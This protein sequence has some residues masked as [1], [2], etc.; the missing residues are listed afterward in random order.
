LAPGVIG[1]TGARIDGVP[2]AIARTT[3]EAPDLYR[4]L[5][6]MRHAGVGA[7]AMEVSSHALAQRR[8]DGMRFDAAVFTNLSH[9]HL[10][11]HGTMEAYF[12]AKARL[13][14][15]DHAA[16]GVVGVED[17]WGRRLVEDAT[18]PIATFAVSS[19]ADLRA[20]SVSVEAHG[21]SFAVDGVFV[22]T[23]LR[24]AFNILNC[25]A[26]LGAARSVGIDLDVAAAPLATRDG[27]RGR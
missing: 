10:D 4:L 9:D 24:G 2:V 5:A 13:F 8:V 11:Y 6:R 18:I 27:A 23:R 25:L 19:P 1:T 21:S 7:V 26:A 14:E 17:P 20:T 15:P 22:R 3:P 16:A 12:E